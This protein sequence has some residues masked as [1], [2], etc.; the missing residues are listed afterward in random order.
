MTTLVDNQ[1]ARRFLSLKQHVTLQAFLTPYKSFK[2]GRIPC[3]NWSFPLTSFSINYTSFPFLTTPNSVNFNSRR[4]ISS[5]FS[6]E[7]AILLMEM[8]TL[9][10]SVQR[11][12]CCGISKYPEGSAQNPHWPIF[13]SRPP[14]IFQKPGKLCGCY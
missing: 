4:D 6:S 5:D 1:L 3:A 14:Q 2:P 13:V 11:F 9:I 8:T 10:R 7:A 12:L